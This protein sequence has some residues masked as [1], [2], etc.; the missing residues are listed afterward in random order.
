MRPASSLAV[1]AATLL[2]LAGCGTATDEGDSTD[3]AEPG[4]SSST[5]SGSTELTIAVRPGA[6]AGTRT[7]TLVCDPPGGDHPDP[8]AA[9]ELLRGLEDPFAPVPADAM[10]TDLYGGPQTATV[11]GTLAGEPVDAEFSRADGCQISRWDA[12]VPLLVEAGGAEGS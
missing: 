11:T 5:P 1:A 6:D 3:R 4:P 2:L 8:D 9:C 7:F 12:Y 10:C